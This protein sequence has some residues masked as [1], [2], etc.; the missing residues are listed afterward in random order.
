MLCIKTLLKLL[1]GISRGR[2]VQVLTLDFSLF[3]VRTASILSGESDVLVYNN[4]VN[5][6]CSDA[7][8]SFLQLQKPEAQATTREISRGVRF[9]SGMHDFD[10][11]D[12]GLGRHPHLLSKMSSENRATFISCH[13][14]PLATTA[15]RAQRVRFGRNS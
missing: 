2:P 13:Q 4:H 1:W 8:V 3:D 7:N 5:P 12:G 14:W 9:S 11:F 10:T 6:L 15:R